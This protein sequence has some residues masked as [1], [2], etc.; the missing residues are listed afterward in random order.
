MA[1]STFTHAIAL[2]AALV[3]SLGADG[4]PAAKTAATPSSSA[5]IAV[6]GVDGIEALADPHNTE[7]LRASGRVRLYVHT[8]AW[9]NIDNTKRAALARPFE[10]TG[11]ASAEVAEAPNFDQYLPKRF[12]YFRAAG[13][14]VDEL[15]VNTAS[16]LTFKLSEQKWHEYVD[17]ARA[18]GVRIVAPVFAPND[19]TS[20]EEPFGLPKWDTLRERARYGGGITVDSPPYYFLR[21]S[22]GY[23]KFVE[24]EIRWAR[25]EGLKATWIISPARES[26]YHFLDE[27]R[28]VLR[29]LEQDDALPSAYIV[30]NYFSKPPEHFRFVIGNER[31]SESI[32]GV[33]RWMVDNAARGRGAPK[34]AAA[35]P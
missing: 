19:R 10:G 31:D 29:R 4:Q 28:K 5:D 14:T 8:W 6:G 18:N 21:Q 32:A 7:R 13:L 23:Q 35:R 25:G 30:E 9:D 34:P 2:F 17:F 20:W 15:N 33:A 1:N 24:D 12:A 27:T 11:P 16:L 26:K 22:P 3:L